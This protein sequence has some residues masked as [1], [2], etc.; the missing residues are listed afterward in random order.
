[1]G[2]LGMDPG[3]KF[4]Y[5]TDIQ[6]FEVNAFSIDSSDGSLTSISAYNTGFYPGRVVVD[7][8]SNFLDLVD[9]GIGLG[10]ISSFSLNLAA[11]TLAPGPSGPLSFATKAGA[12]DIVLQ[13]N[14]KFF[15]VSHGLSSSQTSIPPFTSH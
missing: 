1:A 11:G 6:A 7:P 5:A 15:Y 10:G 4:L 3:G 2:G 8:A 12:E 13:S 9:M 14:W